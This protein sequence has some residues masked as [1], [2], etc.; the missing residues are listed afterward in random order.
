MYCPTFPRRKRLVLPKAT[1]QLPKMHERNGDLIRS[2]YDR[3][4]YMDGCLFAPNTSEYTIDGSFR[5]R[6][7]VHFRLIFKKFLFNAPLIQ[8]TALFARSK[9]GN[10][11]PILWLHHDSV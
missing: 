8:R 11:S 3:F 4:T 1:T 10:G 2:M 5:G 6:F 9:S 7:A